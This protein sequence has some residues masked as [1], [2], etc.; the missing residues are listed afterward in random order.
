MVLLRNRR[1]SPHFGGVKRTEAKRADTF[2]KIKETARAVKPI[3]LIHFPPKLP[4]G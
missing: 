4:Y 1:L 3:V 2:I